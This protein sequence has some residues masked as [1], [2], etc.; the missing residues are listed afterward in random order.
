MKKIIISTILSSILSLAGGTIAPIQAE[1]NTPVLISDSTHSISIYGW[2]PTFDG[3]L[4]YKIPGSGGGDVEID[5]LDKIDM[6]FMADYEMRKGKWS[7]LADMI[8]LDMSDAQETSIIGDNI[9]VASEQELTGWLLSFYGGYCTVDTDN[10]TLDIIAGL[11][12]FSLD[13]DID[14]TVGNTELFSLSP[15][16][17]L[18]DAIIGVKGKVNLN[19]NWYIPYHFDIGAGDSE[20]TWQASTSIGY[21][22][23]WGDTI[24]TYRYVHYDKGDTGLVQDLDMYG[25]KIGVIFY[26]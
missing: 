18:Y 17:T 12:Y 23:D 25:P 2:L 4:N 1:I 16:V 3:S 15:S 20:L 13:F 19:E 22:F 11:R 26:F 9:P 21:R 10:L 7:F 5:W 8:Y 6:F 24:L 14:G